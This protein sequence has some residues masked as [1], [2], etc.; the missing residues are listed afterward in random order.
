MVLNRLEE[1]AAAVKTLQSEFVQEKHL[2]IFRENLVSQG[3]FFFQK[4]DRLRW[5]LVA[6]VQTGFVLNGGEGRRWHGRTGRTEVFRLEREPIM[7]LVAEQ[8]LAWAG[9]DF[10]RLRQEYSIIVLNTEPVTL[11]LEPLGAAAGNFLDHLQVTFAAG[12][13][14]M[15]TIEVHEKSGDFT[16]IRFGAARLNAPVP[17][18]TF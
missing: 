13:R 15:E 2:A 17:P 10:Q 5:E 18:G 1:M 6:P 12:E 7:K 11:R 14:H 8:L 3:R 9:A 4:P 16:R